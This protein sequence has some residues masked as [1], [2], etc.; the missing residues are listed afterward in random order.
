MSVVVGFAPTR[1]GRAALAAGLAEAVRRGSRVVVVDNRRAD[2]DDPDPRATSTAALEA[3]RPEVEEALGADAGAPA[4]EL[5]PL[6]PGA[7]PSADLLAVATDAGADVVV[8]GLRRRT[9]VGKLILGSGA[10]RILFDAPCPVLA[11][12]P[13]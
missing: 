4:Y 1:E 13:S 3:L 5:R 11:V 6:T 9:P 2:P 10:Q 8:I 7:E 12:K